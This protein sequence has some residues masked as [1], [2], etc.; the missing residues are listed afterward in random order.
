[1]PWKT[2]TPCIGSTRAR[3]LHPQRLRMNNV[4]VDS[5]VGCT[6]DQQPRTSAAPVR[7]PRQPM[8]F[9]G[10]TSS[11]LP[12]KARGSTCMDL[13]TSG[14]ARRACTP[15]RVEQCPG[16]QDTTRH[17]EP[18]LSFLSAIPLIRVTSECLER[19]IISCLHRGVL[20]IQ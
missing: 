20:S 7:P 1:M 18:A 10:T 16:D 17:R 15:A 19:P 2:L 3:D 13:W 14:P 12:C 5:L 6:R 8:P 4:L 11:L 9:H